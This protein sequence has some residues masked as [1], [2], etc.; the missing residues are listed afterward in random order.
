MSKKKLRSADFCVIGAGSGGLS[1]A[2]GAVQMGAS[3]ILI[4]RGEMG[5]DCLNYGCVPSKALIAASKFAHEFKRSG[6]FGW[7]PLSPTLDFARVHTHI[8]EVIAAIAPNDS[9]ERFEKLGVKVIQG[10]GA[11]VDPDT[12]ETPKHIIKAKRYI[13]ASGSYPFVPSIE[14]L[15][16]VLYYTNETIFDLKELPKHLVVI[17][18]GPIGVELAQAFQRLGSSVT[19]LEA[20]SALPKDDP[21]L[22]Q[23]LIQILLKEGVSL[24]EHVK[25]TS[26]HKVVKGAQINYS[27]AHQ[28]S[29]SITASHIL[30]AA[31]R[32][33]SIQNLNLDAARIRS[34]SKGITVN[35]H[36]KTSNPRV[37]ALGDCIGEYQFTHV[38]GYHAGLA[39]RN[40][41][42]R[43]RTKVQTSAIPWVTYTDPELAHVGAT[44]SMLQQDK[45]PHRVL[46]FAFHDNDRAQAD[47]RT[48]GQIK[49]LVSRKGHILGASILGA[50]AGELIFPW[51]MAIQ[52][53]MKIS[54]IATT[55]APYPTFMEVSKRVAGSYYTDKIFSSRMRSL[56]KFLMGI[57]K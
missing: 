55:I 51:V 12:V 27:D 30:I 50:Q 20:F 19:I 41:I 36:L 29:H 46:K 3:V 53:K 45:I 56:V 37:Y 49:V 16:N 48:E 44:E 38:A 35:A 18:A 33:P 54:A 22:S 5:G 8:R 25:I 26:V 2:A 42:F 43:F 32:R 47:R 28:K 4:E 31:G 57:R 39:L 17:G 6:D 21:K 24:K 23:K 13:I 7:A 14:G 9:L 1:F 34:T 15:Q 40:S 52:N 11:F 10:E